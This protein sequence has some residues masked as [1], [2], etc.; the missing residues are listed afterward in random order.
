M[1]FLSGITGAVLVIGSSATPFDIVWNSPWPRACADASGVSPTALTRF[2]V[3]TN[4]NMAF[5]GDVISTLY[6]HEAASSI[7]D[8]PSIFPN[9]TIAANGGIPQLGSLEVHLAAVRRDI[10]ALFPD[11]AFDGYVAIDQEMWEPYLNPRATS[12]YMNLSLVAAKG[13]VAAA[14]AAW[15]ASSLEFMAQTLLTAR[16]LRPNAKWGY[17]GIVG[18]YGQWDIAREQCGAVERARNDALAPL[19]AASSALFPS[20]Y[21]SCRYTGGVAPHC[22]PDASQGNAS[23]ATKIPITLREAQRASDARAGGKVPIIAFTWY[24]LYTHTCAKAPPVGLGHCPLMRSEV[25]TVAIEKYCF[26][27]NSLRRKRTFFFLLFVYSYCRLIFA[28]SSRLRRARA[29]Q[30]L[31]CGAATATFGQGRVIA[32]FSERTSTQRS[33]RSYKA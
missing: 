23:E 32:M 20:I 25:R 7:G 15:N 12:V 5:N 2:G 18:C 19:W 16:S 4:A 17:Y 21:S 24:T 11:P 26:I 3:R 8:W 9:G 33:G 22:L 27:I 6:N 1:M 29:L 13:D 10:E 30:A 31:S 14:V 28:Q